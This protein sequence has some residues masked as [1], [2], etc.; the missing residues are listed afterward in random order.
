MTRRSSGALYA[1]HRRPVVSGAEL[2]VRAVTGTAGQPTWV[3]PAEIASIRPGPLVGTSGAPAMRTGGAGAVCDTAGRPRSDKPV[4][5]FLIASGSLAVPPHT[6]DDAGLLGDFRRQHLR[7]S[8]NRS[9]IDPTSTGGHLSLGADPGVTSPIQISRALFDGAAR[10]RAAA[11]A[12]GARV[13]PCST[14]CWRLVGLV[15]QAQTA[16]GQPVP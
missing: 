14:W 4:V 8:A 2:D 12:S 13:A 6:C 3:K 7:D 9:Q 15:L 5:T 16:R 11:G 1:A 10:D